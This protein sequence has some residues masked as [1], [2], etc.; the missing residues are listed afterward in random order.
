MAQFLSPEWMDELGRAAAGHDE[1]A[2]AASGVDLTL[3]QVVT[4]RGRADSRYAIRIS[5]G[6]LEV[7]S[8]A[9]EGA[10]VTLTED[11][12]TAVALSRGDITAQDALM[13]GRIRIQGQTSALVRS[14]EVLGLAQRCFDQVRERT[15]Y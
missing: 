5:G 4:R 1:M 14:Q 6:R 8:G 3:Q 9:A 15:S 13:A 7:V 12:E 10:D 2:E 11:Y